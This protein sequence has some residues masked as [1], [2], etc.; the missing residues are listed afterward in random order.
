MIFWRIVDNQL[1]PVHE[2]NILG[3][4]KDEGLR[5]P[6]EYLDSQEFMVMRTCHGI[7]DWGIISVMPRLLKGKYPK[8]KV[9]VPSKKLLK[10]L[11]EVEHNNVHVVFDNNP[12]VDEF[13]DEIEGEVFHDHYR[14]YDKDTT[15]IP[16][17]K[18][19]LKF[20]QFTDEEMSDSRPEMYWSKEE[21]KLG[22]AII[23]EYVGDKDYGC[24][25]ISDRF[26]Q[27]DNKKYDSEV[28][29]SHHEKLTVLLHQHDYPYFYWSHK[30]ITELGFQFNKR[31]D[32]RHMDLRIQLYIKSKA[33]VNIGN[34][35][36]TTQTISRYSKSYNIQR[37]FPMGS[38]IIEG[39]VYL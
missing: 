16:L 39:E 25:L 11:F 32:M 35:C 24:L 5:I 37:Q 1:H 14:I 9:Y 20:W 6:D 26:G 22:D 10:Q 18:Q 23:S 27:D 38:N 36:G 21:Q 4:E 19:M 31:L 7:G 28:F 3:F 2:T 15:D 29:Q 12:Y 34:Q 30:P 33:K 13:L 8:C 17:L